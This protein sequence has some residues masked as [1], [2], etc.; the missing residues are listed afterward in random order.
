[1]G[2]AAVGALVLAAGLLI[3]GALRLRRGQGQGSAAEAPRVE[4]VL[5][6]LPKGYRA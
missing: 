1:M 4:L 5:L 6:A 2:L 3:D